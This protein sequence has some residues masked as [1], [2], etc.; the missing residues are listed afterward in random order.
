[1]IISACV[2][3]HADKIEDG[4]PHVLNRHDVRLI[5]ETVPPDWTKEIK[6]V[7]IANSLEWNSHTFFSRYLGSLTIYSRNR[8]KEQAIAAV[9]SELAAIS[10]RLDRGLRHRPKAIRDRLKKMT[11]PFL[12]Q[13]LPLVGQPK[14]AKGH[15]SLAGFKE[16]RFPLAPNDAE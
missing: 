5:L 7:R 14:Q 12:Q 4:P 1:V 16:L 2:K 15:V 3:I 9:L 10:L 8:S 11:A 13:L 6:E